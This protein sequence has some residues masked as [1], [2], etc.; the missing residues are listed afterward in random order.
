MIDF[1][2]QEIQDTIMGIRKKATTDKA[3]RELLLND[4]RAAVE[5]FT[6]KTM[7]DDFKLKVIESDPNY[8]M[9]FVLPEMV[10]D[11]ISVEDLEGV[12]GGGTNCVI[13][14][15]ATGAVKSAGA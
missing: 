1:S 9:T 11:Q 5:Q 3:F 15:G 4:P 10:G 14:A 12:P 7:P 2:S 8:H 6:G 13:Y